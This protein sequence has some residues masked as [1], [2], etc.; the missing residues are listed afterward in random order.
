MSLRHDN[1]IAWQRADD[2][3]VK[4]HQLS[5]KALP[6]FERYELGSQLRA[7]RVLRSRE[8]R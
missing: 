7:F 8:H 2:L 3:F 6:A 4:L 1:L 5:Q